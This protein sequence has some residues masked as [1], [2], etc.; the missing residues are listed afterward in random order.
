MKHYSWQRTP[1]GDINIYHV[2]M[3]L[4]STLKTLSLIGVAFAWTTALHCFADAVYYNTDWGSDQE[5]WRV[6]ATACRCIH[7]LPKYKRSC[8]S[9]DPRGPKNRFMLYTGHAATWWTLQRRADTGKAVYGSQVVFL[10]LVMSAWVWCHRLHWHHVFSLGN[11]G[12]LL[13]AAAS[14]QNHNLLSCLEFSSSHLPPIGEGSLLFFILPSSRHSR[15][16]SRQHDACKDD[17]T[18]WDYRTDMASPA[19]IDCFST[20]CLVP[21]I[22]TEWLHGR[23]TGRMVWFVVFLF[24]GCCATSFA[25]CGTRSHESI[26]HRTLHSKSDRLRAARQGQHHVAGRCRGC[27]CQWGDGCWVYW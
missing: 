7:K 21:W 4:Q 13:Y 16:N 6:E 24:T 25:T 11:V 14:C 15:I 3:Q 23:Q 19:A 2:F 18:L 20:A 17:N 12:S 5:E 10:M 8:K 1:F 9:F 27:P 22:A 26:W